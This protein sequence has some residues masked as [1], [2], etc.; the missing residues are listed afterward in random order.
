MI[1]MTLSVY[2]VILVMLILRLE[3]T[4]GGGTGA[5][6]EVVVN[7]SLTS[8]D[9]TEEGSGYIDC[10]LYTSDAADE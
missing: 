5:T 9:V 4:G 8:L 10:L 2:L 3:I 1:S 7:G 6:G